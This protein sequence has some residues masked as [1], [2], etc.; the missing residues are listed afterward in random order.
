MIR[1]QVGEPGPLRCMP[2][3]TRRRFRRECDYDRPR[4]IRGSYRRMP[5]HAQA[6]IPI[7]QISM[8]ANRHL[9]GH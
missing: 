8:A 7:R 5:L 6:T 1:E 9:R 3:V 2:S 4:G